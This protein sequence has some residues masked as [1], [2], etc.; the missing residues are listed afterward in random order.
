MAYKNI[1]RVL[2]HNIYNFFP[3]IIYMNYAVGKSFFNKRIFLYFLWILESLFFIEIL[4]FKRP[5]KTLKRIFMFSTN[6]EGS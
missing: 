6:K 5:N 1:R 2:K 4:P 3:H